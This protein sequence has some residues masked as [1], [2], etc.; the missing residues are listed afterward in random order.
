MIDKESGSRESS[1]SNQSVLSFLD[2]LLMGI[3]H[4]TAYPES[5]Q[6]VGLRG[7][8]FSIPPIGLGNFVEP[9]PILGE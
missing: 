5:P 2:L 8:V 3:T 1:A 9:V 7:C 4:S 6:P